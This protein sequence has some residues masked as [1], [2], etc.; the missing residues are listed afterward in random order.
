MRYGLRCPVTSKIRLLKPAKKSWG[1]LIVELT[2]NAEG[3]LVQASVLASG[4]DAAE[5]Q[6]GAKIDHVARIFRIQANRNEEL[7]ARMMLALHSLESFLCFWGNLEAVHWNQA[8]AFVE[9]ETEEEEKGL[10]LRS[11]T[12]MPAINDPIVD[13]SPEQLD[14]IV[15][16]AQ[17][18]SAM[19]TTL[20]FHRAGI[21]DIRRLEYI[22]AFFNFYFVL[23]GLYANGNFRTDRV[24]YEF[25]KS[26]TLVRAIEN[27]IAEGFPPPMGEDVAVSEMLQAI[28][29][30]CDVRSL[31]HLLVH[32][33]GDLH[34][35]AGAKKKP[36]GS[37]LLNA[38][39]QSFAQ[40]C[41]RV[42]QSVLSA[43]LTASDPVMGTGGP[44]L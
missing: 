8:E 7:H 35:Y 16:H 34:H 18:C 14:L 12:M 20:S 15:G 22:S 3:Y 25:E 27:V 44:R 9:P 37:P 36:A 21:N 17:R 24:K 41:L 5:Y 30:T 28:G 11:W 42:S 1:D 23:E 43:E 40:F 10:D 13:L 4:Q 33:R 29:K 39:Y 19:T 32:T 6:G 31:I 26:A 38:R 2:T